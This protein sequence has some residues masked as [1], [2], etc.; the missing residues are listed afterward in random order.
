MHNPSNLFFSLVLYVYGTKMQIIW[1]W[2]MIY[3]RPTLSPPGHDNVPVTCALA[4][5]SSTCTW[6]RR[7]VFPLGMCQNVLPHLYCLGYP[8]KW[9][10]TWTGHNH[11]YCLLCLVPFQLLDKFTSCNFRGGK[12]IFS[13]LL[14]ACMEPCTRLE[15]LSTAAL[16]AKRD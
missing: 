5:D 14:W 6:G 10:Q 12:K 8:Q 9:A 7:A 1:R 11:I 3:T 16:W 2:T 4:P 13:C 15:H